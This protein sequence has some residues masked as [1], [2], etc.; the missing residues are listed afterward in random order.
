MSLSKFLKTIGNT[1]EEIANYLRTQGIKGRK[2]EDCCPIAV[3]L[4]K[5]TPTM[6]LGLNVRHQTRGFKPNLIHSV[7]IT[8][9]DCQTLDP[10][11][12]E[13]VR[14]FVVDFD[15]GKYP[16][17]EGWSGLEVALLYRKSLPI[18]RRFKKPAYE[19]IEQLIK[20]SGDPWE[21]VNVS[22]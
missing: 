15:D 11:C 10:Y 2:T 18:T 3:A 8:W 12:P 5:H 17:L 4:Y 22:N 1:S 6:P 14:Q 13:A 7:R 9:D 16:D 21:L 20:S 19:K